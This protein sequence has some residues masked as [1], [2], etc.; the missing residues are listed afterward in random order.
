L[1][2]IPYTLAE[3]VVG[4]GQLDAFQ[5]GCEVQIQRQLLG[6]NVEAA[7]QIGAQ[8]GKL[9]PNCGLGLAIDDFPAA[10][11]VDHVQIDGC[12]IGDNLAILAEW[13][14]SALA[15]PPPFALF[16]SH[17]PPPPACAG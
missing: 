17:G 4:L 16:L 9:V 10:L 8:L 11:A 5:P 1:Y 14:N 12:R 2:N 15:A 13:V 3:R 6:V 7:Q